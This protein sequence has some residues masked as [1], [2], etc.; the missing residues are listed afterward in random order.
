MTKL[1]V[2]SSKVTAT[3][4]LYAWSQAYNAGTVFIALSLTKPESEEGTQDTL[5]TLGKDILDLF[6]TEYFTLEEK[7]LESIKGALEKSIQEV[8]ADVTVSIALCA[9]VDDILYVFSKGGGT[10]LLLRDDKIGTALSTDFSDQ[11]LMDASGFAV[12]GDTIAV[13]THQFHQSIPNEQLQSI[14]S[15]KSPDD[16]AEVLVPLVQQSQN[17]AS[18][19][20]IVAC[21]EA[22]DAFVGADTSSESA[23]EEEELSPKEAALETPPLSLLDDD[24]EEVKE[25]SDQGNEIPNLNNATLDELQPD[26]DDDDGEHNSKTNTM[27]SLGN[28]LASISQSSQIGRLVPKRLPRSKRAVLLG[29]VILLIIFVFAIFSNLKNKENQKREELFNSVY[30]QAQKKYDEG[31]TLESLN[32]NLARDDFATAQSILLGNKDKFPK[33]S[34]EE[35]QIQDLLSKVNTQLESASSAYKIST[36]E[37]GSGKDPLLDAALSKK[38]ATGFSSDDT[39][40]YYVNNSGIYS[41]NKKSSSEKQII[42]KDWTTARAIAAYLGNIYLLDPASS[43]IY[44]FVASGDGFV[45]QDYLASKNDLTKA[46]SIAIDGSIWVLTQNGEVLKFTKGNQD[47]YSLSGLDKNFSNPTRIWTSADSDNYYVLD[48]GNQRI[49]E[50]SKE[51]GYVS[52]F[53]SELL[54]NAK[55]FDVD[56]KAKKIYFLSGGKIY[57]FPIQ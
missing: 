19:V 3:P 34:K 11:T 14:L 54:K 31:V 2:K 7:N 53:Q 16:A 4:S 47:S 37:T 50:I 52:Q 42:K 10:I 17:G 5:K 55:E 25:P 51:K 24:Q 9:L 33:D 6:E 22:L 46:T 40:I 48:N 23:I 20:V 57:S 35:K 38:D 56:E 15:G 13:E 49:V 44:K 29:I 36:S 12:S 28:L 39:S 1:T 27:L 18:S 21:E 43:Q 32:K 8:P 45:K 30:P 26:N 41:L